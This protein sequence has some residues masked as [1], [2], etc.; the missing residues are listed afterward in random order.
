MKWEEIA[1]SSQI[2]HGHTKTVLL[3]NGMYMMMQAQ[4]KGEEP[5]LFHG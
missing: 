4:E 3:G 5:C 2:D 1:F